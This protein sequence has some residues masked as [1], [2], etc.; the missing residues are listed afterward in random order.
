[1]SSKIKEKEIFLKLSG[2]DLTSRLALRPA[3]AARV[4]GVSERTLRQILPELPH[5]RIGSGG[6][7]LLPVEGLRAW[8]QDEAKAEKGRAESIAEAILDSMG[9]G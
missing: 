7:V 3:E 9:D 1:M 6:V 2:I 5:L 8:L 4:L